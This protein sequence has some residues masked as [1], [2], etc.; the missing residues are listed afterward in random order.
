MHN[1]VCVVVFYSVHITGLYSSLSS[2]IRT[3]LLFYFFSSLS[4]FYFLTSS[5]CVLH[6]CFDLVVCINL[7]IDV[8]FREIGRPTI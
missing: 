7:I 4:L 5:I 1:A 2:F 3:L 8:V 6:A